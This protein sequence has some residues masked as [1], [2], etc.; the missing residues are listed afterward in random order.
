VVPKEPGPFKAARDA[1]TALGEELAERIPS[2]TI[3]VRNVP[4]GATAQVTIDGAPVPPQTTGEPRKL[5]PGHH[6]VV[7]K[8]GTAEG[9]Q[10]VDLA[11]RDAK[12]IAVELP[13]EAA[14]PASDTSTEAQ[15]AQEDA[16]RSPASK[17]LVIGGFGAAGV[18]LIVG[19]I[20]GILSLS[21]TSS[22]KS[23]AACEGSVCNPSED[24]DISSAR[25]MATVSTVSFVVAGAGAV[26]GV[27]G[28]L[29]H[30]PG[31]TKE[32]PA[33]AWIEPT[34]SPGSF[35]VRGRF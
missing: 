23:S 26:A 15:P 32:N 5:D 2:L 20:T 22:I 31:S 13:A 16:G 30:G 25:T 19:S 12:T 34:F 18:G 24:G 28:L 29:I 11:E 3:N 27:V 17:A 4:D 9:K 14:A 1:A 10:E 7:A 6:V 33:A 35:G 21:K 8:A